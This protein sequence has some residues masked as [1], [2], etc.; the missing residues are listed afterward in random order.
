MARARPAAVHTPVTHDDI[1]FC[2][3]TIM[4]RN[5]AMACR[6]TQSDRDSRVQVRFMSQADSELVRAGSGVS[7]S[8]MVGDSGDF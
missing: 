7:E 2:V 3:G 5:V 4:T 8:E 1:Q 6:R